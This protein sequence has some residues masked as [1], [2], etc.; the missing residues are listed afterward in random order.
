M[1]LICGSSLCDEVRMGVLS[2]SKGVVLINGS[3]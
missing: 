2:G 1:S 3:G